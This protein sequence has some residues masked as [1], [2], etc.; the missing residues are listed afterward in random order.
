MAAPARAQREWFVGNAHDYAAFTMFG[1]IILV[2]VLNALSF[3]HKQ[4]DPNAANRYLLIAIV[5][6][7]SVL[8]LWLFVGDYNVL[9]AEVAAIVLFAVFWGIQ[10]EELWDE[11][12]RPPGTPA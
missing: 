12:L 7:V 2:A 11:G 4:G 1:L 6:P 9:A 8:G 5:M 3:M 10:T